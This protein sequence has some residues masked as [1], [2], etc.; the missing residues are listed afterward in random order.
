MEH[1]NW[2]YTVLTK[3]SKANS[4]TLSKNAGQSN[5][6]SVKK[7]NPEG[8]KMYKILENDT[9]EVPKLSAD[10]RV[11]M[12][13]ARNAKGLTQKELAQKIAV[14]ETIVKSYE[15]GKAVPEN[16]IIQKIEKAL[17]AKLPRPPKPQK[18]KN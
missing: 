5:V 16:H 12:S 18:K 3:N 15:S 10:F 7:S 1:Q 13:Q 4:K 6:V 17:G 2:Q 14:K 8:S 9:L 11:A